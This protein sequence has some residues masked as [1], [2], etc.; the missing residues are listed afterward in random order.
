MVAGNWKMNLD[1]HRAVNLALEVHAE[2]GGHDLGV[3]VGV[4]PAFVH[5]DLVHGALHGAL[6]RIFVGAQDGY[7]GAEGAFTGEVSMPML[8]DVGATAV[9][10]GHSERRHVI[11]ESDALIHQKTLAGLAQGLT[12]VLCIGE[13]LEQ[14]ERGETDR[15]NESQVRSALAGLDAA[16]LKDKLVIAYEPVWAIGTGKTAT[17]ADAQN[18]HQKVRAVMRSMFG[19]A[20]ADA[21][22]ILYGGS[23]KADNAKELFAGPDVDGGLIGGAALSASG[24]AAIVRA[25]AG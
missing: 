7:T 15:I 24:F 6:S 4:F 3:D 18:A 17:P 1:R 20:V 22:R 8:T 13:T 10:V 21:T 25:A 14:R 16:G 12:V 11:K 23:V 19:P 2:V 5:L 9:L